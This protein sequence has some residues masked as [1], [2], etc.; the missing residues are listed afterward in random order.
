MRAL[1]PVRELPD[2]L[3]RIA[4]VRRRLDGGP[5]AV[6]LDYDGTLTPIV[7]DPAAAELEPATRD[8][9]RRLADRCPVGVLSGRD[10]EDVRSRVG[11]EGLYYA[12]SHGFDVRGPDGL[13]VRKAE[14]HL[15]ALDAAAEELRSGLAEVPGAAV[16]RKRFGVAVHWRRAPEDRVGEVRREVRR[17]A[18]EHG[19]LELTRGKKVSELRPAVDWDKGRALRLLLDRMGSGPGPASALYVGDDVTDEDA[20]AAL[21]EARGEQGVAVVVRGEGDGR[22][23]RADYALGDPGAVRRLLEV[24]GGA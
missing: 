16:E 20:F 17:V 4:E 14:D 2:A 13:R 3:E 21:Q 7:D 15:P 8:A 6:L 24:L 10:L 1:R 19:D 9:L 18:G 12:G 5:G 11:M 22:P 23:T